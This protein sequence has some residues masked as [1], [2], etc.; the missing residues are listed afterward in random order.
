MSNAEQKLYYT[1]PDFTKGV[2]L[3][4]SQGKECYGS[5]TEPA[6][7]TQLCLYHNYNQPATAMELSFC[8]RAK[9]SVAARL[10]LLLLHDFA[11]FRG[12]TNRTCCCEAMQPAAQTYLLEPELSLH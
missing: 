1:Q 7:L 8:H 2:S 5:N 4:L 9:P 12:Q 10:G 3:L 6:I 11:S